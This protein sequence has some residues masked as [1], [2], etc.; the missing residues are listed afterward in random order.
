MPGAYETVC[1]IEVLPLLHK[2]ATGATPPVEVADHMIEVALG[3]P[4][5]DTAN[6][7]AA[8]AKVNVPS[9]SATAAAATDE[10]IIPDFIS[11]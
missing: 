10:R 5:H 7:D 11:I 4:E 2:K 9:A 1:D 8:E 6:A 3:V